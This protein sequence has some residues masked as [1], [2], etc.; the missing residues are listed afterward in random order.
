MIQCEP[1]VRNFVRVGLILTKANLQGG[2]G[3]WNTP[4]KTGGP[5]ENVEFWKLYNVV[6]SKSLENLK[7]KFRVNIFLKK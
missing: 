5:K 7:L 6:L 4:K 2:W 3:V 1:V